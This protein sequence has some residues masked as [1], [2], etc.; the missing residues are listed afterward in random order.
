M[1]S[2]IEIYGIS[3]TEMLKDFEALIKVEQDISS[4]VYSNVIKT[5]C[6]E[7][8]ET[9]EYFS[10]N[11]SWDGESVINNIG[12]DHLFNK[13]EL[14]NLIEWYISLSLV[15]NEDN[16]SFDG[17]S[18]NPRYLNQA[19]ILKNQ[20]KDDY[21]FFSYSLELFISLKNKVLQSGYSNF[22][23]EYSF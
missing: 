16:V 19:V 14:L 10:R 20:Y 3:D 21:E 6:F 8:A 2:Q 5:E 9:L 4:L 17:F 22:I 13:T 11:F 23:L 15:F 12:S 7:M 1:S 18:K